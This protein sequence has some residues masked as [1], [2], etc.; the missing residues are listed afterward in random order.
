MEK[1]NKSELANQS[2]L[3]ISYSV[4]VKLSAIGSSGKKNYSSGKLY[5]CVK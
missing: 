2:Q 4:T 3:F 5:F 1:Q